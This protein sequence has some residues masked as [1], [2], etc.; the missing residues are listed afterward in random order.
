MAGSTVFFVIISVIMALLVALFQYFYKSR[1][2]KLNLLLT[3]LRFLTVFSILVLLINPE[4]EKLTVY[5]E[6]PNLVVALDNSESIKH[7]DQ[8]SSEKEFLRTILS[9]QNLK[10][11][12]NIVYYNLGNGITPFDS[13]SFNETE[14]N[15]DKAFKE[16]SQIYKNSVS[17]TLLVTDG[18]QTFGADYQFSTQYYKQP[19]Y[20]IILGDTTAYSDLKIAQLNVNKYAYL[21][22]R[23]PIEAVLVYNGYSNVNTQFQ[24][25]QGNTVVYT[26][27]LNLSESNN[28]KTI[29]LTLPA[30]SVGVQQYK[31]VITAMDSEK[32][33]VN[34]IKNFAVEVIDQKQKIAIVSSFIHPDLGMFKKS[35][36]SNEQRE[37]VILNPN[38]FLSQINDFQL[39]ILYQP[40]NSFSQVVSKIKEL[41]KN[42][43]SVVGT[44]TS[45][46]FINNSTFDF[47]IE[48][49]NQTED[50]Q[51]V[52]N[53][54]YDNFIIEDI[55]FENFPPLKSVYGNIDFEVN[56]EILL[57]KKLRTAITQQ[58]LLVT[59]ENSGRREGILL[60]ENIWKWRAY[61]YLENES[62]NQFDDFIGKIVQYLASNKSKNRLTVDYQSFYNGNSHVIIS[63]QYFNKNYEFDSRESLIITVKNIDSEESREVPFLLK[64]N[65]YQV[66]L[67]GFKAGNYNFTVKALQENLSYSGNFTILEYNVEQQFLNADVT[68][69]NQ[70]ATNS[71]GTSYFIADYNQLFEKLL[72][73]DRYKPIQKS[74][75]NKVPLI[76][77]KYLLFIIAFLLAAEWFIRKYNGLI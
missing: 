8:D 1:R 15:I 44:K 5:N 57:Y 14:T 30:N 55:D 59:Y 20:P 27:N 10:D 23:F 62:F 41:G 73:D 77:Y 71:S 25:F 37:A 54:N 56:A 28:S 24:V 76:D 33:K 7:L 70:I 11:H 13:L 51:G 4:V 61:S 74:T 65:N 58:P 50:Y 60:G 32:N 6:K 35:I 49:T 53:T 64:G 47:A 21:K 43:L 18:N 38:E 26:E 34:N 52:L 67:S 29:N 42:T 3:V 48:N 40:D 75:V 9:N 39:V 12:F 19:I 68:K 17:P 45:I 36:E 66:D 69:L 2:T 63:A 31:A 46:N 72:N 16:L 22:N